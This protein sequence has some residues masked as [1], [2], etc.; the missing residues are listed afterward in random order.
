[1]NKKI[2]LAILG[3]LG[4]LGI[5]FQATAAPVFTVNPTQLGGSGTFNAD[6]MSGISSELLHVD[7]TALSQYTATSG[8]I[9]FQGFSNGGVAV[10]PS[11]SN[12]LITY[13]LYAT[14]NFSAHL[15]GGGPLTGPNTQVLDTLNFTF[16]G[17]QF[18]GGGPNAGTIATFIQADAASSTEATVTQGSKDI[19]L[20]SGS[21][22]SG[23]AGLDGL[24]G[25]FI[26]TVTTYAN[27]NPAGNGF[28]VAPDPF[29]NLAFQAF[30]NTL[31]GTLD[32]Q[33]DC[34][35][36]PT[37]NCRIAITQAVGAN[38]FGQTQVP[39]PFTLTLLGMGLVGAG[40]CRRLRKV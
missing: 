24:G 3:M 18:A 21:L 6:L 22:I 30:N 26:N 5:P 4:V 9:Q 14:F 7:S 19:K 34:T 29:Y 36:S 23:V 17:N 33:G 11:A 35:S 32:Q 25:A 16:W 15:V 12:L 2:I 37:S 39:E 40:V 10:F 20:G 8:W 28:F 31:Q 38:D 13:Q 1:M 27:T